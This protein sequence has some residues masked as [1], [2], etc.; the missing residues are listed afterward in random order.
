MT[1]SCPV[2]TS[3]EFQDEGCSTTCPLRSFGGCL[4][5]LVDAPGGSGIVGHFDNLHVPDGLG[6][7]RSTLV[8]HLLD[9]HTNRR[10]RHADHDCFD[11]GNLF[12]ARNHRSQRRQYILLCHAECHRIA[13]HPSTMLTQSHGF[14]EANDCD[15]P[16]DTRS[17]NGR[18]YPVLV[19][20]LAFAVL[21]TVAPVPAVLGPL[22]VVF[23]VA[24]TVEPASADA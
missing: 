23:F 14:Y 21:A 3:T 2:V 8:G 16:Y 12:H 24:A 13:W 11:P 7:S 17:Y 1:K 10:N 6:C 18:Y 4:H 15:S 22:L 19:A 20:V 9:G 5:C